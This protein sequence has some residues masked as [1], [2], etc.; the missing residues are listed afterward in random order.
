MKRSELKEIIKASMLED[1]GTSPFLE[2][3]PERIEDFINSLDNLIE[4]Y[5]ADLY[6]NDELFTA[7]DAVKRAAK[8]EMG[9]E[10]EMGD[11]PGFEGTRDALDGLGLEEAKKDEEE[12]EV[13]DVEVDAEE[14]ITL[15]EP[16]EEEMDME[17]EPDTSGLDAGEKDLQNN[18]EKAL[19][20]AK[21][22][23]DEK[24]AK[25]IGNTITFFTRTHVVGDAGSVE[26]VEVEEVELNEGYT[27]MQKLAGII[28]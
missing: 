9:R 10:D 27:R 2:N 11:I 26:E 15:D 7:I 3:K 14:D 23:G 13:E 25:Q 1:M 16:E 8:Q 20:A 24:L 5:H 22:M 18:L 21:E 6:L 19:E 17:P 28:K 4:E 12:E